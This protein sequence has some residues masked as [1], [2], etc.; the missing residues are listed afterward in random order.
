MS[1]KNIAK[2]KPT[3]KPPKK[4]DEEEVRDSLGITKKDY[5][6]VGVVAVL[7]VNFWAFNHDAMLFRLIVIG[8]D[9]AIVY[10]LYTRYLAQYIPKRGVKKESTKATP[11]AVSHPQTET[12]DKRGLFGIKTKHYPLLAGAVLLLVNVSAFLNGPLAF[13]I[14]A[15][16]MDLG[17]TVYFAYRKYGLPW[18]RGR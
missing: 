10:M 7:V 8:L 9:F 12:G 18:R 3:K 17:V 6:I 16:I 1:E 15:V 4:K 11:K 5:P 2:P 13:I 14:V